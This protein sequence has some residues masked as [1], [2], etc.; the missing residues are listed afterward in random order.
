MALVRIAGDAT[1]EQH[2]VDTGCPRVH[3]CSCFIPS[4]PTL[5]VIITNV[6]ITITSSGS[7]V[8]IVT[9]AG[10]SEGG[11]QRNALGCSH[12][13]RGLNKLCLLLERRYEGRT[14]EKQII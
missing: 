8:T 7:N 10:G 9:P 13:D 3:G 12:V 14:S 6:T 2:G 5:V 11:E 1:G 4:I